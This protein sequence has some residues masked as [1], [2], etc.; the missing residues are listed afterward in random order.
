APP[1]YASAPGSGAADARDPRDA[2]ERYGRV[3]YPGTPYENPDSSG[4]LS[5]IRPKIVEPL[6]QP[7]TSQPSPRSPAGVAAVFAEPTDGNRHGGTWGACWRG[8][9][10]TARACAKAS[11]EGGRT[12]SQPCVQVA[13]SRPGEQ[14]AVARA[15]GFG[16]SWA[17]CGQN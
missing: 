17:A 8:D 4:Q 3:V 12:S 14:C 11:C 15:A 5:H 16:V 2:N 13:L 7:D 10:S 9:S 6:P 1:A